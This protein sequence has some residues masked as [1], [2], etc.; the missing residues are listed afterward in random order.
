METE[1]HEY[2]TIIMLEDYNMP[3]SI[4]KAVGEDD[5]KPILFYLQ[6]WDYGGESEH[7]PIYDAPYGT[8]D[9]WEVFP[10]YGEWKYI[11]AW[12]SGMA[13]AT[14][15]RF[16]AVEKEEEDEATLQFLDRIEAEMRYK[17]NP[18]EKPMGD[19]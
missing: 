15:I 14:L 1:L 7:S 4:L 12:N 3:P 11:V 10:A 13:Y 8:H 5:P 18:P 16:R 17:N 19:E 6:Q 2:H 9:K